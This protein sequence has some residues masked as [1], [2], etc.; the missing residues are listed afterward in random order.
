MSA[1]PYPDYSD[2]GISWLGRLPSHWRLKQL[3]HVAAVIPSNVDKHS[4]D[5]ESPVSLCN[6][7]DVY[8][9]DR[10]TEEID[11]MRA[12]ASRSE[13]DRFRLLADDV[14]V[15]KDSETA[16]DIGVPSYVPDTLPEVICGYHLSIIRP[17]TH[18]TGRFLKYV[19]LSDPTR[20]YFEISAKGLTR[21]GLSQDA[22]GNTPTPT[23]PRHEQEVIADF[24]DH[25]TARIDELIEEQQRL[26]ER[27]QEKRQAAISR[28]V[29][30]GVHPNASYKDSGSVLFGQIPS[31]WELKKLKHVSPQV[32]VGIVVEPA[33]YY[34]DQGVPALRSINIRQGRINSENLVYISPEAHRSLSKSE[35]REGDVVVVRS[36]QPGTA[37]VVPAEFDRANCIDL[38][39]IRKATDG[40]EWFLSWC[41]AAE[42][43]KRQFS[44]GSDGAIQQHF[45]IATASNLTVPWPPQ[46]EQEAIVRWIS[47]ELEELHSLVDA[48][49]RQIDLLRERRGAL[50]SAAVT[51]KINVS[52]WDRVTPSNEHEVPQVAEKE[53]RYG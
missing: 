11:F 29:T 51:G 45:N 20:Y 35:I 53:G 6:Y 22:L 28:A 1:A 36:G 47:G 15:T 26:I 21:V 8:Y 17:T 34:V 4:K 44:E 38:I 46:A 18:A 50:V 52:E 10:I 23:P 42:C 30:K 49:Q 43:S 19:L 25:E 9:R 14:V 12:T 16:E 5:D 2:C 7:T 31:H 13:I 33:K 24:L 3:K 27:L 39:I 37:A 32:T 41:L 48:A 40:S